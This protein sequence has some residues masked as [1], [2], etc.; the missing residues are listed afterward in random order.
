MAVCIVVVPLP[1]GEVSLQLQ[2]EVVQ[3]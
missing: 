2:Q 3:V 1:D